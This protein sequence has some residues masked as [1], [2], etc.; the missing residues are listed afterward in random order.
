SNDTSIIQYGVTP[1]GLFADSVYNAI[2]FRNRIETDVYNLLYQ[3]PTKIP[4]TDGGNALI[5]ATISAACE[6]AVNNGYLAPGV[7]NSAGFGALNQ[8]D[9]LA[10]GYYVYAPPIATQSQ[11]DREA[12]K[13]VTFQ[14]AAKE[15]G[16]IHSVDIIVTVNR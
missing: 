13:S 15:A 6:A 9:T 8:G 7:W 1:S 2:W 12:R 16:A 4:Q 10:K 11:A 5:A 3:S 14:V